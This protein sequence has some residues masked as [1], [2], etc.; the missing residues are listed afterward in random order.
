[1]S[2]CFAGLEGCIIVTINLSAAI[3][4][5]DIAAQANGLLYLCFALMAFLAPPIVRHIG[6]KTSMVLSMAL[7]LLYLASYIA[8]HPVVMLVNASVGGCAGALLWVAQG[9]YFTRNALAYD[10]ACAASSTGTSC[11]IFGADSISA[12]AGVFATTFQLAVTLAKQSS[13]VLLTLFPEDRT[14]LFAALTVAGAACTVAMLAI[15]PLRH[16]SCRSGNLFVLLCDY[17]ALL[18]TPYNVAFGVATAFF[19]VHITVLTKDVFGGD[20]AAVCWMYT[21]AGLSSATAAALAAVASQR[22]SWARACTMLLGSLSFGAACLLV[23][24]GVRDGGPEGPQVNP[25]LLGAMYVCFGLGVAAW[26]GSCMATVGHLFRDDPRA[27]F[28]HLKL[29]SGIPSALGFFLLPRLSLRHAA[30]ATCGAS[31]VG[32]LGLVALLVMPQQGE[33]VAVETNESGADGRGAPTTARGFES[34]FHHL[35]VRE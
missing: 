22:I 14:V 35:N 10:E 23:A 4:S 2:T 31:A 18:L 6:A 5:P 21:I 7:Y 27:A 9:V 34:Q 26:Q 33:T 19:P 1:M 25:V 32:A 20:T 8:A 11:R 28:A 30:L 12:F 15:L 13:C 16:G 24:L 29:T 17:R 3:V